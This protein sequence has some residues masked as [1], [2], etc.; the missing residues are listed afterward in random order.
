MT[1][2]A[3]FQEPVPSQHQLVELRSPAVEYFHIPVEMKV[4]RIRL[5]L[6]IARVFFQVTQQLGVRGEVNHI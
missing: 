6:R 5:R 2:Q 3:A 1:Y 4:E